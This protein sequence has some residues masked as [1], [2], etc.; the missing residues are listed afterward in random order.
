MITLHTRV[1]NNTTAQAGVSFTNTASYTYTDIPAGSVTSGTSGSADHRRAFR[2][3]RQERES[4]DAAH[5][6]EH[7]DLYGESDGGLGRQLL[8][9]L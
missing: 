5:S 6:G 8:Q 4:G 7:P 3:R 1:A 9:R 2:H